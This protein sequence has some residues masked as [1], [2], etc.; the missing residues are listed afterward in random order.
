[1]KKLLSILLTAVI[2]ISLLPAT[3]FAAT[4][5]D[6]PSSHWAYSQIAEMSQRGV[7][8]GYPDGNFYPENTVTRAEFAK[9]MTVAAGLPIS[10]YSIYF[11]DLK[12]NA[13]YIPY[14]NAARYYLNGYSTT[15]DLWGFKIPNR[16]DPQATLYLPEQAAVREDIA[17]ALVKL[18]GYSTDEAD[19]SILTTMFDDVSSISYE[20][21]E[22][23]AVAVERGLVS[24]YDDRTFRGQATITRAEATA[25]L[26]RAY[27]YGNDNKKFDIKITPVPTDNKSNDNTD[28]TTYTTPKPIATPK[29]TVTPKP[30]ATLEPEPTEEPERP[31]VV[32]TIAKASILQNTVYYTYETWANHYETDETKVGASWSMQEDGKGNLYYYDTTDEAVYKL[33]IDSE[34]L[35]TVY[36][37]PEDLMLRFDD[38]FDYEVSEDEVYVSDDPKNPDNIVEYYKDFS[39]EEFFYNKSDG[40]LILKGTFKTLTDSY[41]PKDKSA[42][43]TVYIDI[44][45]GDEPVVCDAISNDSAGY[46]YAKDSHATD[47]TSWYTSYYYTYKIGY[48]Y[49]IEKDN[50]IY[51]FSNKVH[52]DY[53]GNTG[54]KSN[55]LS[56]Y[57]YNTDE[58]ETIRE[59]I[60]GSYVG[61]KDE[62]LYVW[63][64]ENGTIATC[65]LNTKLTELPFNTI[66]DVDVLDK[67]V[68]PRYSGDN[69][70][71]I[72]INDNESI[73]FYDEDENAIRIIKER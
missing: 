4:F 5:K 18:K 60:V 40:R 59:N 53:L 55:V 46:V 1:M 30:T 73:I 25:M 11:D 47:P 19:E 37:L 16:P 15:F 48:E 21:K 24:G 41:S 52:R 45:N 31:Y 39:V 35:T 33:N 50:K 57:S 26:W 72:F 68:V 62:K 27:Q 13:W 58:W 70:R 64:A 67:K 32:D 14:I 36:E 69:F 20:A 54:S 65:A 23:V 2:S 66:E 17:V 44:T 34:R 10:D 38:R 22:Y 71:Q 12:Q 61:L 6:V 8:N 43:H 9:I 29:P 63:D 51:E 3:V 49:K 28:N 56:M 7:I 42:T